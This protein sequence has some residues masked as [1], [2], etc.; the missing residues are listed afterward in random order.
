M[1]SWHY[2]SALLFSFSAILESIIIYSPPISTNLTSLFLFL[3][4]KGLMDFTRAPLLLGAGLASGA[5]YIFYSSP[6]LGLLE[7][8]LS[9]LVAL[10]SFCASLICFYCYST[11]LNIL[12]SSLSLSLFSLNFSTFLAIL[13]ANLRALSISSGSLGLKS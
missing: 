12:L 1:L 3:T 11:S 9:S 7:A 2:F 4:F 5:N 13:S 8:V 10:R 6:F